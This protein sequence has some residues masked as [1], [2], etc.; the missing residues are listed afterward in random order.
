M[1]TQQQK[2][3]TPAQGQPPPDRNAPD[4]KE[5]ITNKP[6]E[7]RITNTPDNPHVEQ[8]EGAPTTGTPSEKPIKD[9]QERTPDRETPA[10][11]A[12][13]MDRTNENKGKTEGSKGSYKDPQPA[14]GMMPPTEETG[15][16][17]SPLAKEAPLSGKPEDYQD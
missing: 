12:E 17:R 16:Y 1:S 2:G 3:S 13:G 15:K 7:E 9:S 11:G 14:S 4:P 8:E 6:A 10:W 5:R